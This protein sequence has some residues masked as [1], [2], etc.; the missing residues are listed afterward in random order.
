MRLKYQ[1]VFNSPLLEGCPQ[2]GVFYS[3][4][5]DRPFSFGTK[6]TSVA[7][8][9]AVENIKAHEK[10]KVSAENFCIEVSAWA[11]PVD[12]QKFVRPI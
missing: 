6:K 3:S 9:N 2:D 8:L 4:W 10:T 5:P 11:W 1:S 12:S 7:S